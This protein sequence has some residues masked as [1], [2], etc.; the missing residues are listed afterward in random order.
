MLALLSIPGRGGGVKPACLRL[1]SLPKE[2]VG[3]AIAH[4]IGQVFERLSRLAIGFRGFRVW[5]SL[6]L[7]DGK[8]RFS[9][10]SKKRHLRHVSA[11]PV[12]K[13]LRVA[14]QGML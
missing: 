10:T 12:C 1:H 3:K 2:P 11:P 9:D 8:G 6:V 7:R 5:R 13:R 4:W 14:C